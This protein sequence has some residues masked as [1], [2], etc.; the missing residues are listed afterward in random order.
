MLNTSIKKVYYPIKEKYKE[1]HHCGT[2]E[3]MAGIGDSA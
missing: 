1:D 3:P 2:A